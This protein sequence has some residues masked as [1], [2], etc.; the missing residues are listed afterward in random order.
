MTNHQML[1]NLV[2]TEGG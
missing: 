1:Q 2:F